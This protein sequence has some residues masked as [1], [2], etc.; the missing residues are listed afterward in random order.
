MTKNFLHKFIA[1]AC[2]LGLSPI[3]PGTAGA[4][5]AGL[6]GYLILNYLP[7]SSIILLFLIVIFFFLGVYSSNK[8][9]PEWGKDPS[10]IVIDEVV[11]MWISMLFIPQGWPYLIASFV[12]F[13]FFDIRKPLY[14]KRAENL[15]GGWGIM[16]DDV[17]AGIY[18]N[19][20][21][22]LSRLVI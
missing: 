13:R 5:G 19:V 17:V 3:A 10:K 2:G 4:L 11:G 6:I 15:K 18:T 14:I 21:I 1:T 12:L 7:N 16:M 8:L 22:Q 9:E 20:L